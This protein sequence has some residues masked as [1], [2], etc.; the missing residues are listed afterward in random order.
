MKIKN[1]DFKYLIIFNLIFIASLY[2]DVLMPSNYYRNEK[3]KSFF[4]VI[5]ETQG[6][7]TNGSK[8]IKYILE[9]ESG[10]LYYLAKFPLKFENIK[11]GKEVEI[12]QTILFKKTKNIKVEQKTYLVSFLSL[13]LVVYIFIFCITIN[14]LNVF[15]SNK[16]LDIALAFGTVPIYFIGLVYLF[17]Y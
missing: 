2:F 3:V 11:I 14:L 9:C 10:N 7:K 6:W 1:R 17:A 12:E 5:N 8:E 4:N 15:F 13:N 16:V